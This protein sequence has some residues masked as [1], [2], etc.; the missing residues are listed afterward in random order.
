MITHFQ[1]TNPAHLA[2]NPAFGE[3]NV[4]VDGSGGL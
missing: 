4:S 1:E 2:S 3:P